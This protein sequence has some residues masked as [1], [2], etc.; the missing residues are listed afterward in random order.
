M[1]YKIEYQSILETYKFET[2]S[3]NVKKLY[4]MDINNNI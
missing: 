2:N 1:K 3:K 4:L